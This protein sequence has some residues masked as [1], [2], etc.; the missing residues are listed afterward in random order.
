[1]NDRSE[2]VHSIKQLLLGFVGG[3]EGSDDDGVLW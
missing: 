2:V 3:A 1:M